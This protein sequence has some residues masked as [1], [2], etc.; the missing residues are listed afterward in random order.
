MERNFSFFWGALIF[1]AFL[2]AASASD[3]AG[4]QKCEQWAGK[5]AS[6]QGK[7][8]SLAA[9]ETEWRQVALDETFCPGDQIRVLENSRADLLLNNEGVMRLGENTSITLESATEDKSTVLD[10]VK[11]AGH[12]F[13]TKPNS[14]EVKTPY[15]VAGVRG[16]EF[17]INVEENKTSLSIFA[18]AV[19]AQ[20][21]LGRLELT[22]GQSAVAEAGKAPVLRVV[23]KPRDAVQWALYY[24]PL[25]YAP[26]GAVQA[27]REKPDAR[28]Y[29]QRASELLAVGSVDEAKANIDKALG[30]SPNLGDAYALQSIIAVVQNDKDKALGLAQS[31]VKADPKSAAAYL[32]LSYAQQARFD[33]DGARKSLLEAVNQ[34][35]QNALAWA[36]LAEVWSMSGNLDKSLDAAQKAVSLAPNL[37]RTQTVLGFA[38]LTE[39][40]TDQ[41]RKAFQKAVEL[42]QADPMPRLGLGLAIIRGGDLREGGKQ[43]EIAASLDPNNSLIRSYLGKVFYEEKRGTLDEREFKIAEELDPK[44]P[45]PWFYDAVAKQT[46]NRPVEALQDYQKA[47][48]LNDNRAV[49]RSKLLLDSDE[50]ARGVGLA[51]IYSALGFEQRALVEGWEAVNLDPS[52]YSAHRFLADEYSVLPRHEIARVSEL[53]QSQLLQPLNIAPLEPRLGQSN[54]F[55]LSTLG[56][57]ASGFNE[58]NPALFGRNQVNFLAGGIVGERGTYAGEG[59]VSAIQDNV[60]MSGGFS[61]FETQGWREYS[62]QYTD[63]GNFFIQSALSPKLNVQV[64]YRYAN[65]DRGD[66]QLR[67]FDQDFTPLDNTDRT[68]SIRAGFH[69]AFAPGSDLI[70]NFAYQNEK[71]NQ[72][73]NFSLP[74]IK[75]ME[76]FSVITPQDG[77]S[78]EVQYLFRSERVSLVGGAGYFRVDRDV[79]YLYQV[80]PPY[81]SLTSNFQNTVTDHFNVYLYS[82][83]NLLDN[84]VA[85]IGASGD[86][87]WQTVKDDTS[88]DHNADQFN[89]KFGLTWNPLPWTT[90]R[91]AVFRTMNRD[92]LT[93]QTLEPTQVAGFNQFYDDLNETKAWT[94][95]GGVDQKFTECIFGGVEAYHRSLTVPYTFSPDPNVL[96]DEKA[97]WSETLARTYLYWTPQKWLAFTGEYQYEQLNRDPEFTLYEQNVSTHKV[98]LGV[99]F[100]HPCGLTA[101]LKG[102]FYDQTGNFQRSNGSFQHGQDDFFV[103]DAVLSYRLP[104]RYGFITFG[105]KNLADQ[106]FQFADTDINNPSIRPCRIAFGQITLYLP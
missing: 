89:P 69:Y 19:L 63:L 52:N 13:S 84:L 103:M 104:K 29:A 2:L 37:S 71:S 42:D 46:T 50:A 64:E 34:E 21:D 36:R 102:T 32:A 53:L 86:F 88:T 54:L 101:G 57:A 43:I 45:T 39:I 62:Y 80:L 51:S 97:P 15:T 73:E 70:G 38:Y 72:L 30:I 20:N 24:P 95:G 83:I 82:N 5:V 48:D 1:S 10:M 41:A 25:I 79:T 106:H 76:L 23:A 7:V 3:A 17:L 40:K 28:V 87:I 55:L 49:Y 91:A 33:V 6:V 12:F 90:V 60:S 85:T 94:Y 68:N 58:F 16:T 78:G 44:D 22:S 92:L 98:P 67:F 75:F 18:G 8:E 61:H 27:G 26:E 100:F 74:A 59:V 99:M 11:G 66:T 96:L 81:A 14:L 47:M 35:P 4:A 56:P 65:T 31:A 9:G 105:V 77:Y 93:S